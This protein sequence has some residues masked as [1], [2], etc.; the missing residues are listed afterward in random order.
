MNIGYRC[1]GQG[2][3]VS[4]PEFAVGTCEGVLDGTEIYMARVSGQYLVPGDQE[5]GVYLIVEFYDED[6]GLPVEISG[7]ATMDVSVSG[8]SCGCSQMYANLVSVGWGIPT[9]SSFG[10]LDISAETIPVERFHQDE[11]Y[12]PTEIP[13]FEGA[14]RYVFFLRGQSLGCSEPQYVVWV[15]PCIAAISFDNLSV[16]PEIPESNFTATPYSG[17]VPLE[18]QFTDIS[19]G[20]PTGWLWDFGDGTA[21]NEQNPVHIYTESGIYAVS[22]TVANS[23]GSD[24]LTKQDCIS[25]HEPEPEPPVPFFIATPVAGF[26]P[27]E[28]QFADESEGEPTE[29]SWDF[30]DGNVSTE[31]NPI[32][33]Y[34]DPGEYAVSL[35]VTNSAGSELLTKQDYI[36]AL[37]AVPEI[38]EIPMILVG[39]V[40]YD[41]DVRVL[42]DRDIPVA[43]ALVVIEDV[44]VETDEDGAFELLVPATYYPDRKVP[45]SAY[46]TAPGKVGVRRTIKCESGTAI[47]IFLWDVSCYCG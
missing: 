12:V 14:S 33:I 2:T 43:R 4:T 32:H 24:T 1:V 38:P 10:E 25:V 15:S 34:I 19:G 39:G 28:V 8:Y 44:V 27:L 46:V 3:F 35:T 41:A 29:W 36:L 16:G 6:T 21:S 47:V 30:G 20:D 42:T 31:Q 40:V 45:V 23:A 11:V 5:L 9:G 18:V 7:V 22:L 13:A 26:V 37:D 17:F